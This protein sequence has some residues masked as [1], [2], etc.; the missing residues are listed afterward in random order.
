MSYK[1]FPIFCT[2]ITIM[3]VFERER[4]CTNGFITLKNAYADS[5]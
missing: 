5:K 3:C 4:L 1:E 2:T